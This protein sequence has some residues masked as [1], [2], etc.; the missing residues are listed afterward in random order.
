ML[1][2]F[3]GPPDISW[4][5]APKK[6]DTALGEIMKDRVSS[7]INA[8]KSGKFIEFELISRP[9][10]LNSFALSKLWHR[11]HTLDLKV[12][13]ITM[14]SNKVKSWMFQDPLEKTDELSIYGLIHVGGLG[15]HNV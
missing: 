12:M 6:L 14:I 9:G 5:R 15:L 11:C 7:T 3:Q 1:S 10:P 2:L 13:D 4:H 8:C